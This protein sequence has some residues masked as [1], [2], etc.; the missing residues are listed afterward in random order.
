[1]KTILATGQFL[2]LVR[3]GHWEYAERVQ[4]RGAVLIV[5]LTDSEEVLLV[6]QY[7][8]PLHAPVIELP[9]GIIGDEPLSG[10]ESR[11]EAARRELLEETGYAAEKMEPLI[12]GPGSSGMSSEIV[13]LFRATGLRRAGAGGGVAHEKIVL[14]QVPLRQAFDWLRDQAGA[15]LLI[16][17]KVYAGLYFLEN[18]R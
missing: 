10:G 1:M 6:E 13:T 16:D 3:E 18:R 11:A 8:V 14:H 17:P 5:A 4:E 2:T 15:G 9:A 7:R 12:A